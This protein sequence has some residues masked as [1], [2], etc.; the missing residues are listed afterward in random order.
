MQ[1]SIFVSQQGQLTTRVCLFLREFDPC[2][3]MLQLDETRSSLPLTFS[4]ATWLC[5]DS[6][7]IATSL[8]LAMLFSKWHADAQT[9]DQPC[10]GYARWVAW[11]CLR[12][13]LHAMAGPTCQDTSAARARC[14]SFTAQRAD[15]LS[16]MDMT[17]VEAR[18]AITPRQFY[19]APRSWQNGLETVLFSSPA[20]LGSWLMLRNLHHSYRTE[21]GTT[22]MTDPSTLLTFVRS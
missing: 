17:S 13:H 10:V 5:S 6:R 8:R 19:I 14:S 4:L 2:V 7:K 15:R 12:R 21:A 20:S 18:A 9:L 22:A 3:S 16:E 11:S 1:V